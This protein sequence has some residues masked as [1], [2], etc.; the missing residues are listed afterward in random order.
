MVQSTKAT[1]CAAS[2][3]VKARLPSK[4]AGNEIPNNYC[5]ALLYLWTTGTG[6][7]RPTNMSL[8]DCPK[9]NL[10]LTCMLYV[11]CNP[12]RSPAVATIMAISRRSRCGAAVP[13][14]VLTALNIR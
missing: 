8:V 10:T 13:T 11:S 6:F 5:S 9:T 4:M 12:I 3:T 14:L 2:V 1:G 7:V